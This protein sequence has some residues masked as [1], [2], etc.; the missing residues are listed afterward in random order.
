LFFNQS[1]EKKIPPVRARGG[2]ENPERRE[3]R[4]KKGQKKGQLSGET[5]SDLLRPCLNLFPPF[6]DRK[7]VP[8]IEGT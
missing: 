8:Q 7:D 3:K 5:S 4:K 2:P 6:S 1:V